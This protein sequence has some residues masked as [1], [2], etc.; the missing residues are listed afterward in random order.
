MR[1]VEHRPPRFGNPGA[2][3]SAQH[4]AGASAACAQHA[5]DARLGSTGSGVPSGGARHRGP[6]GG[7]FVRNT[8]CHDHNGCTAPPA[9]GSWRTGTFAPQGPRTPR[10]RPN[11]L[12]G[13]VPVRHTHEAP[14][15]SARCR[16]R[17]GRQA[18]RRIRPLPRPPSSA[19]AQYPRRIACLDQ[20]A[21][22]LLNGAARLD[23]LQGVQPGQHLL[24]PSSP[25]TPGQGR[26]T[27]VRR[28]IRLLASEYARFLT[29]VH[30]ML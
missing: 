3:L 13:C 27:H 22:L 2:S 25:S 5:P 14:P 10:P 16:T 15:S 30:M 18:G 9:H 12:D 24:K 11:V 17:Y 29:S 4:G 26:H 21:C 28:Q 6:D 23:A 20:P 7:R 1:S 19:G 8:G